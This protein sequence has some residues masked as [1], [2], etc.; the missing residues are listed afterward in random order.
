[1]AAVFG[2]RG[3][4]YR[5][6]HRPWRELHISKENDIYCT[7]F[8]EHPLIHRHAH[9]VVFH[10][11]RYHGINCHV[12]ELRLLNRQI[13]H[14]RTGKQQAAS[15]LCFPDGL[16]D[17]LPPLLEPE[18]VFDAPAR[19]RE[20]VVAYTCNALFLALKCGGRPA[21]AP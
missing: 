10:P 11:C 18:P 3:S 19:A 12:L 5:P 20:I 9:S 14:I 13:F 16:E 2:L 8:I 1:M 21:W 6:D 7:W 4:D 15:A 17:V